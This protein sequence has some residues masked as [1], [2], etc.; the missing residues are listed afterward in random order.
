MKRSTFSVMA[1]ITLMLGIIAQASCS[2][3]LSPFDVL[4][5]APLAMDRAS[6]TARLEFTLSTEQVKRA[7]KLGLMVALEF[8][9]TQDFHLED[10]IHDT[11][12][13]VT[14][15]VAYV[16]N[17]QLISIL[18][19][20]PQPINDVLSGNENVTA[21]HMHGW[22]NTTSFVLVTRFRP[23]QP[24]HYIATVKTVRDQPLF[25]GVP[26]T[27]KVAGPYNPGE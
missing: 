7:N 22:D 8:P 18:A 26:T 24:G 13:P 4:A 14:V 21:L 15:D 23:S 17:G 3:D 10:A 11:S 19:K 1:C 20:N 5:T 2:K 25:A 12:M 27:V 9:K 16:E 6:A